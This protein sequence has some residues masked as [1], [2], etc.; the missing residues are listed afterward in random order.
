MVS[1][2]KHPL[3]AIRAKRPLFDESKEDDNADRQQE[4]EN[5]RDDPKP[6]GSRKCHAQKENAES[7]AET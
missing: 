2:R 4:R 5:R 7:N 1:V 6:A 3:T